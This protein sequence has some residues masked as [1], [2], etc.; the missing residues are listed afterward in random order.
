MPRRSR[1]AWASAGV[2]V[3]V[4][5]SVAA[6]SVVGGARGEQRGRGDAAEEAERPAAVDEGPDVVDEPAV[7]LVDD[8]AFGIAPFRVGSVMG[9]GGVLSLG[10]ESNQLHV[11]LD[12]Q[13]T[14]YAFSLCRQ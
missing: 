11:P 9:H 1:S 2:A 10:V 3:A 6:A 4:G 14:V 12:L 8:P 5:L 13:W 7:L